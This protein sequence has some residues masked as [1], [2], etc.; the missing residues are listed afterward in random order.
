MCSVLG[1]THGHLPPA[2][3]FGVS[4]IK[5]ET[6]LTLGAA[7]G[8]GGGAAGTVPYVAPEC[9]AAAAGLSSERVSEKSG[10]RRRRRRRRAR[11]GL[12]GYRAP[13]G[14]HRARPGAALGW[15]V[16]TDT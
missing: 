9:F 8:G 10:A 5:A 2:P 15:A 14:L 1:F 16:A 12:G 11:A 7:G 3:S 4:A 13:A 6:Y